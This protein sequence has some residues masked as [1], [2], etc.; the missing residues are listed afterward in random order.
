MSIIEK[1]RSKMDERA[2]HTYAHSTCVYMGEEEFK[3]FS[4][5]AELLCLYVCLYGRAPADSVAYVGNMLF[6]LTVVEVK[7][8]NYLEV[9]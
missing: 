1:V 9:A 6:G 4:K 8:P 7:Q 3:E 2:Q 5:E